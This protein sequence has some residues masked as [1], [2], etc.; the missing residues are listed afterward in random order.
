MNQ[1]ILV[2]GS[3]GF[4]GFHL[5]ELLLRKDFFVI[6]VDCLTDYYDQNL[7]LD[8]LNILL[9]Y[10]KFVDVRID[11]TNFDKLSEVFEQ[12]S[13]DFVIHLAAQAG[14]R[15]SIQNPRSYLESNINGTFNI[16]ELIKENK[17]KHTLLASTSSVYGAN[18][19]MPFIETQKTENQISF[20][21]AT[22]K[23][24]EILSHSYSHIYNLP[25]T[26]FRFFTVYG[27]W[28][29]PD[30]AL[31][32]FVKAIHEKKTIDIYNY[33]E[34]KRDFT[35]ISDLVEAI[36]L[37]IKC[38]PKKDQK[39]SK[40]DSL[41]SV[42]PWRVINIGNSKVKNLS[43]F[44]KEIEINLG[45]VA[46]KNYLPMQTGDV[47]ETFANNDLLYSLTGFKPKTDIKQGIR[48]F[49]NWYKE[50]YLN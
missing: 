8:R 7:K 21:A 47:K 35:Y 48:N 15:Y 11:I 36:S 10:E 41:S 18:T 38:I 14:V 44:I 1:K 6:G 12:Y 39:V 42:A 9:K 45:V 49:C 17:I 46:A 24:C 43:D 28:G 32:K 33:G 23:S 29:R 40:L 34:M 25:I 26:N 3:A 30:M 27:P 13:P 5:S 19:D 31:F 22:K 50:Y 2:T 37:L 4:I 16:L 20:Y